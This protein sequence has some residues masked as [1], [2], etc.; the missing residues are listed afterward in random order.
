MW[1]RVETTLL[2]QFIQDV[3]HEL[4]ACEFGCKAD[5]CSQ[6]KW[7]RCERRI[8]FARQLEEFDRLSSVTSKPTPGERFHMPATNV[9]ANYDPH[10]ADK[11]R[12]YETTEYPNEL[13]R[14]VGEYTLSEAA[15][16]LS[17]NEEW[18]GFLLERNGGCWKARGYLILRQKADAPA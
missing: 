2:R 4:A 13:Q 3:P 12:I 9:N 11:I 18:L 8:L 7:E 6:D 15:K 14:L 17:M 10:G 5:E 16:F 1:S